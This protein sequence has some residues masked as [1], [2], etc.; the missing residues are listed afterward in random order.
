MSSDLFR[1]GNFDEYTGGIALD[2]AN[3][4]YIAGYT[5]STSFP[6]TANAFQ[7]QKSGSDDFFVAE[8]G[9]GGGGSSGPYTV[10]VP[11]TQR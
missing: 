5:E 9:S 10:H 11:L 4:A 7:V 8:I 3:N 2:S 1:G 6:V